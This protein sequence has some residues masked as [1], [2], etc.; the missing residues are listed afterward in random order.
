MSTLKAGDVVRLKSGGPKMT[1]TQVGTPAYSNAELVW[2]VWFLSSTK[3]ETGTFPV[4][5]VEAV[6]DEPDRPAVIRSSPRGR[7]TPTWF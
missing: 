6:T 7:I 3:Q 5:A 1:V 2:C 4:E